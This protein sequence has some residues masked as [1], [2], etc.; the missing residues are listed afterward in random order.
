MS[1]DQQGYV[2]VTSEGRLLGDY[3]V[4]LVQLRSQRPGEE[5]EVIK[6]MVMSCNQVDTFMLDLETS[7]LEALQLYMNRNAALQDLQSD[8]DKWAD[9][10]PPEEEPPSE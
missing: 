6:T 9:A 5:Q 1:E 10:P 8:L 4:V 3:P 2:F 7:K